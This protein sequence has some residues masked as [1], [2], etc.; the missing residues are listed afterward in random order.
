MGQCG[1]EL[2]GSEEKQVV[3]C[4]KHRIYHIKLRTA[5]HKCV[6]SPM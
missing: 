6:F 5:K 1:L 4:C 3:V 2:R